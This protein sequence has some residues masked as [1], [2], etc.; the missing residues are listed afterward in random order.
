MA[1]LYSHC[2]NGHQ[3]P[4]LDDLHIVLQQILGGFNSSYIILDALDECSEREK[5]LDWVQTIILHKNGNVKLHLIITSRPEKEI[6]DKFNSYHCVDLVKASGNHNIVAYLDYQF[7]TDFDWQKWNEEIQDEI[8]STLIRQA[9]GMYVFNHYLNGRIVAKFTCRFR[10]VALQL[11]ELKKC[12]TRK[13]IR[14]QLQNLPEGLDETYDRILLGVDKKDCGYTRTFLVWLCFAVRPM[15]LVELAA[16]ITVDLAAESG[17]QLEC[18][19]EI[20][21]I[22][23]VLKMCSSFVIESECMFDISPD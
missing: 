16:T 13:A 3:Q 14:E 11:M 18:E 2:G 1:D 20:Q 22:S 23:D 21:D 19:N 5:V 15:T 8:K 10:W 7:Q 4:S 6:K 9:D 17:P 12:R